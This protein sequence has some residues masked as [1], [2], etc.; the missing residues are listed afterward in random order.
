MLAEEDLLMVVAVATKMKLEGV[1][2]AEGQMVGVM[3]AVMVVAMAVV[4]VVV[5]LEVMLMLAGVKLAGM[6]EEQLGLPVEETA[7]VELNGLKAV[8]RQ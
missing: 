4:K 3:L 7:E 5:R 1:M 2:L 8:G 6:E